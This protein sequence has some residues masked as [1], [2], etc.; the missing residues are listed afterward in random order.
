MSPTIRTVQKIDAAGVPLGRLATRDATFLIGKHKPTFTPNMDQGDEVEVI[1]A[2]K[3]V[4][5]GK[6]KL[7]QKK[8][9][10]HSGYHQG[11]KVKS[12]KQMWVRDPGEALRRSVSR[13]L[14]KN[15]H[16]TNRLKRLKIS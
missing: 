16:R 9:Y 5:T 6:N 1:H 4:L 7:D 14:P 15:R 13:M 2:N 11:L 3:M 12:L 8:Y 10:S